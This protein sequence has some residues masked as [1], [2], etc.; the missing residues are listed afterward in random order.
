MA[1]KGKR[2]PASV[3]S[4]PEGEKKTGQVE[5]PGSGSTPVA[6]AEVTRLEKSLSD[7]LGEFDG[8]LLSE[9]E[10]LA[11]R[12]PKQREGSATGSGGYGAEGS[13]GPAGG[14]GIAGG[15]Y[16]GEGGDGRAGAGGSGQPGS[17]A[18]G[19]G[20][21]APAG[22][23]STI[24]TDDDIVAR[25]LREAAEKETDPALKEKLWQE[26]RKYKQGGG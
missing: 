5:H 8:K 20:K 23:R 19:G 22:G 3:G 17:V 13:L 21:P 12:I 24:D 1:E 15:G 2:Q 7:A 16:E 10:R 11:A 18:A 9:Q 4:G 26:Y 25:Q 14:G 6:D